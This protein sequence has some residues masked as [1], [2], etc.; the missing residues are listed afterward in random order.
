[1]LPSLALAVNTLLHPSFFFSLFFFFFFIPNVLPYVHFLRI[2][3][4]TDM[5]SNVSEVPGLS[6][7][8]HLS[9]EK[10]RQLE[11]VLESILALPV[12]QDTYAQIIDGERIRQPLLDGSTQ[13]SS[14]ETAIVNDRPKPSNWAIQQYKEFMKG[15][16]DT[17]KINTEVCWRSTLIDHCPHID[18][19]V[20]GPEVPECALG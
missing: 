5:G 7:L 14:T 16:V 1:M 10:L 13:G 8:I 15:F 2:T 12:A 3:Y 17:L 9:A 4:N 19:D 20:A 18:F 11:I 6:G